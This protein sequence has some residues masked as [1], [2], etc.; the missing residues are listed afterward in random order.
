LESVNIAI[1]CFVSIAEKDIILTRD[2]LLIDL[3]CAISSV[4]LRKRNFIIRIRELRRH[5]TF[6][7]SDIALSI[8]QTRSAA[9]EFRKKNPA[10]PRC[11]VLNVSITSAGYVY[12]MQRG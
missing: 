12:M 3:T 7:S 8:A 4:R 2:A 9:S 1:S 11:N 6:F 10:V 5:L